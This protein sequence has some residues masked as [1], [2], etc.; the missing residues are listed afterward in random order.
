MVVRILGI[1]DIVLSAIV[2][3]IVCSIRRSSINDKLTSTLNW[4]IIGI[5]FILIRVLFIAF[6]EIFE[7]GIDIEVR[8]IV[9]LAITLVTLI[10][11]ALSALKFK[12]FI[13]EYRLSGITR[14]AK[15]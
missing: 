9:S 5:L 3:Y 12:A 8:T 2:V 7:T 15:Y 6:D 13:K 14:A 11:F 4:L 1:A 10:S